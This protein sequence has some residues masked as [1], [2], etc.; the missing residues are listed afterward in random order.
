MR[1]RLEY[2]LTRIVLGSLRRL[3]LPLAD[4]LARTLVRVLDGA[5][6][7]LRRTAYRNLAFALPHHDARAVTDGVFQSIAR[8]LVAF[9]RLPDMHAQNVGDWIR[10][11][12]LEHYRVAK[13]AGRGVLVATGHIGNWELSA[14]A[15]AL[16]TEPMSVVVRPLDNPAIDRLV[17]E[18]RALSGNRVITKKDALRRIVAAL[19]ANEAVGVLVDQNASL[20]EG[21]FVPF[22]GRDACSGRAFARIAH[23]TGAAVIPGYALW[24]RAERKYVL[25]FEPP[26]EIA[27]DDAADTARIHERL[28]AVIRNNPDQW[29]W[30][31]RRWKTRPPGQTAL[32]EVSRK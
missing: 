31:H 9:A 15:H 7:R 23:R 20:E 1:H 29:L 24:N 5:L 18:R 27:G 12:G 2:L 6:P 8:L 3:P 30:I 22:F 28:G 11:E 21:V 32:C 4:G 26:V 19:R 17:E 14:F 13:N 10:C 25:R 16:L